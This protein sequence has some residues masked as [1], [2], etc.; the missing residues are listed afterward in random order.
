MVSAVIVAAGSGTRM[1]NS[2]RK[3]YLIL[4]GRPVLSHTLLIF[5]SCHFIDKIFLVVPEKDFNFCCKNIILPLKL[6]KKIDLVSGGKRRQDSVYNGL[7]AADNADN[8]KEGIVAIHDG[9][10]P[11]IRPCQLET[12]IDG[13]KKFGA[14]ILGI[15]AFET[16]KQTDNA[17]FT[18]KT[19]NRDDV[20]LAQTP[21]A[22]KCSIIIK[23]HENARREGYTGT[24][25]AQ[26][27]E[28]LGKKVKVTKGS[29]FNIKITTEEDLLLADLIIN[30]F[31]QI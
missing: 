16:L 5:D 13:A 30:S 17:C 14:C 23:A 20:W 29:R 4:A 3:Q 2:V 11:F 19:I 21:Q 7:V 12:C 18:A 24:D 8:K 22:F 27:V 15:P 28:R 9:V 6:H 31:K 10:R 25:D 26:L 1:N